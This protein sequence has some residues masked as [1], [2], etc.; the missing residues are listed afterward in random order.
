MNWK[1]RR[2][3]KNINPYIVAKIENIESGIGV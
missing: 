3:N 1:I 2:G